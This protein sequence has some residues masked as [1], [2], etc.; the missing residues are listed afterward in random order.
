M[1][2]IPQAS[3]PTPLLLPGDGDEVLL[4]REPS[5]GDPGGGSGVPQALR[6]ALDIAGGMA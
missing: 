1:Q 2:S 4:P 3:P 6:M 5:R